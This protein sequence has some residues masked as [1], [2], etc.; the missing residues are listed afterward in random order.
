MKMSSYVLCSLVI[1]FLP[2]GAAQTKPDPRGTIQ[3][4]VVDSETGEPLVG[5]SVNLATLYHLYGRPR[6]ASAR[7]NGEGVFT[8]RQPP[9]EYYFLTAGKFGYISDDA[10]PEK[11]LSLVAGERRTGFVFKLLRE[12]VVRGRL[13]DADGDLVARTEVSAWQWRFAAG[14]RYLAPSGSV[15]PRP[16]GSFRI[17]G[18]RPGN[19]YLRA[20][21][22]WQDA[23]FGGR[24]RV[25]ASAP[26]FYRNAVDA[27][28]AEPIR[29]TP[30]AVID[31]IELRMR[32]AV[33]YRVQGSFTGP[34]GL[35]RPQL[36]LCAVWFQRFCLNPILQSDGRFTID[37]VPA[38]EYAIGGEAFLRTPLPQSLRA[39][40]LVTVGDDLED[41]SVVFSPVPEVKTTIQGGQG[42]FQLLTLPESAYAATLR[43]GNVAGPHADRVYPGHYRVVTVRL[44]E[45]MYVESIRSGDRDVTDG[46]RLAMTGVSL[47][48]VLAPG[49]VRLSGTVRDAQGKPL[50]EAP[51]TVW[52]EADIARTVARTAMSNHDGAYELANLPPGD[53]RIA[54]WQ[55][56]S[57]G[58][59]QYREFF[60]AFA[61]VA[62]TIKLAAGATEQLDLTAIGER[63]AALQAAKVR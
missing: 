43:D 17:G 39:S 53:Y 4:I 62:K 49:A 28:S 32:R 19:V 23:D 33:L 30:G 51:V 5:A 29:I 34:E 61:S 37:N 36:S 7:T 2:T 58:I 18:L 56:I 25:D 27:A 40:Q 45:G 22:S 31:G 52:T 6:V 35:E 21:R 59:A 20:L 26:T 14:Q 38:G 41:V 48:I 10:E 54:A 3:G 8:F 47:H 24:P 13:A 9:N 55:G 16:D 1:W 12:G 46:F 44:P 60:G 57:E 63:A 11:R 42:T 50:A 15:L